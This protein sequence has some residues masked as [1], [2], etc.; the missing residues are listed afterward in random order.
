MGRLEHSVP[1]DDWVAIHIFAAPEGTS[2]PRN[3]ALSIQIRPNELDFIVGPLP[4]GKYVLG[5]Y[6]SKRVQVDAHAHTY[7]NTAPTFFPGVKDAGKATVI[8]VGSGQKVT[9]KNFQLLDLE[10]TN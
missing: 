5:A 7:R 3:A 8:T 6:V 9:N 1:T 10:L 4:A 2:D